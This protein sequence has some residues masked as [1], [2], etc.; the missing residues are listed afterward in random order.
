M[1]FAL[2]PDPGPKLTE[3]IAARAAAAGLV[4]SPS[5]ARYEARWRLVGL[6][7]GVDR[8]L[9]SDDDADPRSSA[10]ATRA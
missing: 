2:D 8:G 7:E 3:A 4:A 1:A 5:D 6:A 9:V 10:G